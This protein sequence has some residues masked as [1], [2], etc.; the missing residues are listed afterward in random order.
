MSA[1]QTYFL[2]FLKEIRLPDA[3]RQELLLSRKKIGKARGDMIE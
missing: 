1:I 3:S 2:D